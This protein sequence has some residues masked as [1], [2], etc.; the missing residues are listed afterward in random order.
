MDETTDSCGRSVLNILF[1]YHNKTKLVNT[2]FLEVVNYTTISQSFINT[3]N[4]YNI[5]FDNIIF[6]ISD[7]AS[8]MKKAFTSILSPLIPQL[9]HNTCFA[10]IY[11]LV[12]ETWVEFEHFKLLDIVVKNIKTSFVYSAARK[13]RWREHLILRSVH[14]NEDE[15]LFEEETI[16][17]LSVNLPPLPVKTRW[18]SWFKFVIWMKDYYQHFITFFIQEHAIQSSN[19]IKELKEIFENQNQCFYVEILIRF[20]SFNAQR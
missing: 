3:I 10:H 20:I 7:N 2:I 4:S 15:A 12:R 9:F 13:R 18:N 14:L 8:Y 6:Y 11:N 19:A 17:D 16:Q 1:S 5:S